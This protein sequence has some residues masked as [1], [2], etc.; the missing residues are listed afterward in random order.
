MIK[1]QNL[2][3]STLISYHATEGGDSSS[4]ESESC[5]PAMLEISTKIH[6]PENSFH[7]DEYMCRQVGL[8]GETHKWELIPGWK[9]RAPKKQRNTHQEHYF[10][11]DLRRR[12]W[13]QLPD[14]LASSSSSPVSSSALATWSPCW[15]LRWF[16][17]NHRPCTGA[18][19]DSPLQSESSSPSESNL[20]SQVFVPPLSRYFTPL[21]KA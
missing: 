9:A 11:Y 10:G 15:V 6:V 8:I 20:E 16:S 19:L 18:Y 12:S 13:Y 4:C 7:F 5:Q 3:C 21:N 17:V 14:A 1:T 2:I